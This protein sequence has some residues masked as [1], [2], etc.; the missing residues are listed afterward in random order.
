MTQDPGKVKDEVELICEVVGTRFDLDPGLPRPPLGVIPA[1]TQT[2]RTPCLTDGLEARQ[3][4]ENALNKGN[5]LSQFRVKSR[6]V[7]CRLLGSC[8]GFVGES[9]GRQSNGTLISSACNYRHYTSA[10]GYGG[11]IS[12][13]TSCCNR[14]TVSI[15]RGLS[16]QSLGS[17]TI[18]YTRPVA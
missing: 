6:H 15:P 4:L 16:P 8:Y 5:K 18:P 11:P 10:N 13:Q 1:N 9:S 3:M 12:Q 17:V 14:T 7:L 2:P